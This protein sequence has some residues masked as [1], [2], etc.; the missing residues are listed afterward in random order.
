[1]MLARAAV[2]TVTWTPRL[3]ASIS[4]A[5]QALVAEVSHLDRQA[6][7]RAGD[8]RQP[9]L[10]QRDPLSLLTCSRP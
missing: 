10:G 6:L 4:A 3:T 1:M 5:V 9:L 8:Q 2:S 7:L